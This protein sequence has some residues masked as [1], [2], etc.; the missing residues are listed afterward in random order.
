N[1]ELNAE[2]LDAIATLDSKVSSFF[3][4]RDPEIIKWMGSRKLNL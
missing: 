3:D 2:D 1:F 4:H